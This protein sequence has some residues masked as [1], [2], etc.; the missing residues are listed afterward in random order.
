MSFTKQFITLSGL[1]CALS[2]A[3]TG[4]AHAAE[5]TATF[6]VQI[7]IQE[8][9]T[10]SATAPTD[11]DF[12]SHTRSTGAPVTATGTLTVNCSAGTPYSIGLSGGAHSMADATTPSAGDR[13]MSSGSDF[14]PYDLFRDGSF[15]NF[16]GNTGSDMQTGTGTA[17]NQAFTVHGRVASTDFPAGTYTDTVTARVVY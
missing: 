4:G 10:I 7:V 17:A 1:A 16:W 2:L 13:R 3:M 12:L 11:I 6:K 8:S 15:S 14:V 5:D 9:C